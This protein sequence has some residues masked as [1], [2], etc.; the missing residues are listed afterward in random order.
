MVVKA[1]RR[2]ASNLLPCC[3]AASRPIYAHT[4][5][6]M[7]HV[8]ELTVERAVAAKRHHEIYKS[9]WHDVETK[10][11][12]CNRAGGTAMQYKLSPF[13][14]VAL[15]HPLVSCQRAARYVRDKLLRNGFRVVASDFGHAG[16]LL[17]IDW[18]Q[19]RPLR[20]VDVFGAGAGKATTGAPSI[21]SRQLWLDQL[22]KS[23]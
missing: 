20:A 2:N 18:Q 13:N 9:L 17:D 10:V 22:A 12:A 4:H 5:H 23:G 14:I 1:G 19:K 11:Q 16:V 7:V 3:S 15:G 21:P 8:R 6:D